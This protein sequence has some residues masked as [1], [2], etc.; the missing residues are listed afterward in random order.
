MPGALRR[1]LG[2]QRPDVHAVTEI[3]NGTRTLYVVRGKI[4]V[5]RR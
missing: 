1:A 4:I 5:E 2:Q 3:S